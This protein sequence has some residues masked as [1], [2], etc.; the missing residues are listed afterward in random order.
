MINSMARVLAFSLTL[1]ALAVTSSSAEEAKQ[2]DIPE[3][4]LTGKLLRNY[5]MLGSGEMLK[6][7]ILYLEEPITINGNPDSQSRPNR[8]TV[9]N[10]QQILVEFASEEP[11]D[12]VL[13]DIVLLTGR[14]LNEPSGPHH[15][16]ILMKAETL[17]I[18]E[19]MTGEGPV[20]TFKT[21]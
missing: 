19:E 2:F 17:I 20:A 9:R 5:V 4:S 1:H 16:K 11:A 10:I 13:G 7:N 21:H 12:E 15:T 14:L 6:G 3:T 18:I 8:K